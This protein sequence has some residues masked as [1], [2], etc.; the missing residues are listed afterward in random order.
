M[1]INENCFILLSLPKEAKFY[2]LIEIIWSEKNENNLL[3][4]FYDLDDTGK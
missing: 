1:S 3:C 2:S 4:S